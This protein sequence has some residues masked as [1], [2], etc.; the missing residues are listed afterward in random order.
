MR[1]S[2]CRSADSR[3]RQAGIIESDR[4]RQIG[5][6]GS[7]TVDTSDVWSTPVTD[8]TIYLGN[9]DEH[10]QNRDW[11]RIMAKR[12]GAERNQTDQ[13]DGKGNAIAGNVSMT[14]LDP[15]DI[16]ASWDSLQRLICGDDAEADE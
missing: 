16:D 4:W 13:A 12:R 14:F 5:S 2:V 9:V 7:D 6:S 3:F 15:D 11:L 10:P 1:L 8:R